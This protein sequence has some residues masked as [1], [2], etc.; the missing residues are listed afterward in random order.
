MRMYRA[1]CPAIGKPPA[2]KAQSC[3]DRQHES[4]RAALRCRWRKGREELPILAFDT[5]GV[6]EGL[7]EDED[8]VVLEELDRMADDY[9]EAAAS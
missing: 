1:F 8:L 7:T 4:I 9:A 5:A 2:A 6:P 3:C